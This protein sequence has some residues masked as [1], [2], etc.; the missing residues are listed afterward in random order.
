MNQHDPTLSPAV[1][2]AL[3]AVV[4]AVDA[5]EPEQLLALIVSVAAIQS[6]AAV[7]L[8]TAPVTKADVAANEAK[9]VWWTVAEAARRWRKSSCWVRRAI[10]KGEVRGAKKLGGEWR[11]PVSEVLSPH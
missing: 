6:R 2:Q 11:I 3:N 8:L 4:D 9:D 5:C 1:V 10:K 7:R